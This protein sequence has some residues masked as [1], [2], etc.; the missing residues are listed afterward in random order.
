MYKNWCIMKNIDS[1]YLIQIPGFM[2][3]EVILSGKSISLWGPSELDLVSQILN[4][5][6]SH[7]CKLSVFS[8]I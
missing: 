1:G 3:T 7:S 5:Y 6:I 2:V 4:L 8:M